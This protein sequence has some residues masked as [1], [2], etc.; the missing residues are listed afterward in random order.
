MSSVTAVVPATMCVRV[1]VVAAVS[2]MVH[3]DGQFEP[4]FR[5]S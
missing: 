5:Y 1:G 4:L 3:R 2:A